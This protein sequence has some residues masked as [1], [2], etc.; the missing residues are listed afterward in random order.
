M[1]RKYL[2]LTVTLACVLG[3]E[4]AGGQSCKCVHDSRSAFRIT[5]CVDIL[6]HDHDVFPHD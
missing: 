3:V 6:L 4:L 1:D 5:K 2:L